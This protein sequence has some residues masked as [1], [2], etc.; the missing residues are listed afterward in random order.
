[1]KTKNI[2]KFIPES[3]ADKIETHSFILESNPE[4]MQ[5]PHQLEY[6]LIILV[7]QGSGTF[8]FDGS[9][10]Y[11]CPGTIVFGFS[12]ETFFASPDSMCEYMY[13][14]FSGIR[15]ETLFRR[16]GINKN[17]R[18]F[19]KCDGLIPLWHESLSRASKENIDLASESVL[20]Y[21]FSRFSGIS[22]EKS[23]LINKIIEFSEQH[24]TNSELS[25]SAVAEHLSY[26]PKYVSH[27]F[28][29]KMGVGY[30][31]YLRNLRIKYAISLLDHGID[32]I[33]NVAL[34]SGFSDPLYFS[35]VF[36]K[37]VG[38]SPNEYKADRR[39]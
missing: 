2:C 32:S 1:M 11:F 15:S 28:K 37:T 35:S 25:L 10:I 19:P 36:K 17:N 12:G 6:N 34:L 23:D 20:L 18:H 31:E 22:A 14:Q 26:N 5:T 33:K 3:S 9:T 38:K 21:T 27:I 39:G 8:D 24:F 30:S 13:I 29:E 7:K 4:T 16:F